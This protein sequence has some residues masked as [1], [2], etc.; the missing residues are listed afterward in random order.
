MTALFV[1]PRWAFSENRAP[2]FE[3]MP[4]QVRLPSLP[5][6]AIPSAEPNPEDQSSTLGAAGGHQP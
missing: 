5:S 6:F 3:D 2:F 4:M 1:G